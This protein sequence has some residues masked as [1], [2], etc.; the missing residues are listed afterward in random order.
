MAVIKNSYKG[1]KTMANWLKNPP[2]FGSW[3][4][5]GA[6]IVVVLLIGSFLTGSGIIKLPAFLTLAA[7]IPT[8]PVP[9]SSPAVT[10]TGGAV[11][12][13][14]QVTTVNLQ[15]YVSESVADTTGVF[16]KVGGS[17]AWYY[18][19]TPSAF[20]TTTLSTTAFASSATDPN[21]N[22][23]I[24]GVFTNASYYSAFVAGGS[25]ANGMP[26]PLTTPY[27]NNF[28]V[29]GDKLAN[30]LNTVTIQCQNTTSG[31]WASTSVTQTM[32]TDE[33]VTINCK[34]KGGSARGIF[35]DPI[36][37]GLDFDTANYST[38]GTYIVGAVKGSVPSG[39]M[40][41]YETAWD[42][43]IPSI[44]DFNEQTFQ[45]RITP[46]SGNNPS[47]A[48]LTIEANDCGATFTKNVWPVLFQGCE[49]SDTLAAIGS[50]DATFSILVN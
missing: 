29:K 19:G 44:T 28:E 45:L 1:E 8:A 30:L 23:K 7:V 40:A 9:V 31:T 17:V 38:T 48:N 24:V 3:V 6:F 26:I 33:A 2:I 37:I 43:S 36:K 22:S 42:T 32:G 4:S 35:K 18:D 15:T 50:T 21:P 5:A 34:I 13:N 16:N 11:S 25:D 39:T 12:T 49:N 27:L 10:A 20:D 14:V 41:G 47:L 46:Q